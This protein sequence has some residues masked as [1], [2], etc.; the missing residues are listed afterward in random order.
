M[1][2]TDKKSVLIIDD[3]AFH[4]SLL[5]GI[6]KSDFIVYTENNGRNAIESIKK[7]KPDIILLD[8]VMPGMDGFE[9]ITKIKDDD[10]IKD[11]PV[12]FITGTGKP[13][14]EEK[15]FSLGAVDYMY[16]LLSPSIIKLRVHNQIKLLEKQRITKKEQELMKQSILKQQI[17]FQDILDM[18][19]VGVRIV[20]FKDEELVYA[21]KASMDIFGCENFEKDVK[22]KSAFDFMPKMQPNGRTTVDMAEELFKTDKVPMEFQCFKL[23]G[24]LFTALITSCNVLFDG[25][26]SS[27]A[28][29]EDITKQKET[30]TILSNVLNG[31]NMMI[32]VTD[33]KTNKIL[34]INKFMKN[35]YNIKDDCI[36]KICYEILQ[37]KQDERCDFCPC[38]Q[39][40]KN[41]DDIVIWENRN[42]LTNR[43]YHNVDNFINWSDGSKV[44]MQHSIDMTDLITARK[45]AEKSNQAK[46]DFL[47]KMSHE[48][49]T[50]MNAIIGMTELALREN[51]VNTI[52]EHICTVKH[53]GENLLAIINDI[54]DFSKIEVGKF[55][56]KTEIYSLSSLI[57]DVISIIKMKLIDSQIRFVVNIDSRIPEIL[58]G[59]ATRVR[60]ILINVLENAV[61][62]TETGHISFS[63][64]GDFINDT[65]INIIFTIEDSGI[66]I[67]Q[68]NIGKLFDN[69]TQFD[70]EKNKGKEG[71]G[72]G[73][74]I[75]HRIVREMDGN[76]TVESKYGEGSAFTI[77]VPQKY[78]SKKSLAKVE[79]NINK[80][81]IIYENR[82]IYEKSIVS[83][84]CN[85]DVKY[86]CVKDDLD[87][88]NKLSTNAYNFL[89]ISFALYKE[90]KEALVK[91]KDNIKIV[92][93][94]DF[95]EYIADK[96]LN[97]LSMPVY[98]ISIANILNDKY[99]D[100]NYNLS[101]K[102]STGFI[103]PN[104]TILIVDDIETNLKVAQGLLL[105]Y[106]MQVELCKS[107][108]EAIKLAQSKKYDLIFMDHKMPGMDGVETT[109]HI[110]VWGEDDSYYKNLPIIALTANAVSGTKEM[111]LK[112]GF[113]D[114]LSKPIDTIKLDNMLAKW[115]PKNKQTK[116]TAKQNSTE[117][118]KNHIKADELD[119]D[120]GILNSGGKKE[121]YLETLSAFYKEGFDKILHIKK[122]LEEGNITLYT[123]HIHGI[124]NAASVI[125]ADKLSKR[126]YSLETAGE[127]ND[128]DFIKMNN[129][130]FIKDLKS[131]LDKI[132]VVI[133]AENIEIDV[134]IEDLKPE[135]EK[136]KAAFDIFKISDMHKIT[137]NLLKSTK[138]TAIHNIIKKISDNI[139]IGE[140]DEA[141]MLIE[142][143]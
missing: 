19:P 129:Y 76:I 63:V 78:S 138:G 124:K 23:N 83:T 41:P 44:H 103:A 119:I 21:N 65:I 115:I 107:G 49:R 97:V 70:M 45:T 139:L 85:L 89:L 136:L 20:R 81:V 12:M 102:E 42:S 28:V 48:I 143:L 141:K 1:K 8:I 56:V 67:K 4:L 11:I 61:K 14:E 6:L 121:F 52:H 82:D 71:V 114:F 31:I 26:L 15:G 53:A 111:F 135:F 86:T 117:L 64:A 9:V 112:N 25:E 110:R 106:D 3:I 91:S 43:I 105:P 47:A 126:A 35:H 132:Y 125:G 100:F 137:D 72:L 127:N 55:A 36:G 29:I 113:N 118:F 50:P 122:A 96:N 37:N 2:T 10:E 18:L 79:D 120:K 38:Y 84:L 90:N 140:Y 74:A 142:K 123:T 104:S 13:E 51:Q 116:L 16:K 128:F 57:N 101:S 99:D 34:F 94:S 58:T 133:N 80:N 68:E 98:C 5:E 39:L 33:P 66:G 131:V 46:S 17:N 134:D 77:T 109:K 88:Q 32:Y 30:F 130:I 87:L 60:Q 7:Y 24:E 73:L 40:E 93:L 62:Y 54:L 69:F 27:L 59:D 95:G 108:N 22:G 92:V 75:V